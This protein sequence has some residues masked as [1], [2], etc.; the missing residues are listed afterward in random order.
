MLLSGRQGLQCMHVY[1]HIINIYVMIEIWE[2]VNG[3]LVIK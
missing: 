1:K 2:T 3:Y